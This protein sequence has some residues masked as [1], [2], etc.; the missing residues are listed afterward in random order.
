MIVG[1]SPRKGKAFLG[2]QVPKL[3]QEAIKSFG[4]VCS[5]PTQYC[6]HGNYTSLSKHITV[7][8]M[9]IRDSPVGPHCVH[10]V[11]HGRSCTACRLQFIYYHHHYCSTVL[12]CIWS[13]EDSNELFT[14]S[15]LHLGQLSSYWVHV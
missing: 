10:K 1:I 7:L 12:Y 5:L 4:L 8:H 9:L 13:I 15:F 3:T 11:D 2:E 6:L 14:F